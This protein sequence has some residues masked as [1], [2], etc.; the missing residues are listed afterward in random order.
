MQ[1]RADLW[2]RS[3]YAVVSRAVGPAYR[4][5]SKYVFHNLRREIPRFFYSPVY[6]CAFN[7]SVYYIDKAR[8]QNSYAYL[9]LHEA[10]RA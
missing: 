7:A 8:A 5:S 6:L 9:F 2:H 4:H 10:I 1:N 3:Y